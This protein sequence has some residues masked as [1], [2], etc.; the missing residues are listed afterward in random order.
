MMCFV[1]LHHRS[2]TLGNFWLKSLALLY[3]LHLCTCQEALVLE[4]RQEGQGNYTLILN[5]EAH[6]MMKIDKK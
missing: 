6:L 2:L 5:N 4:A 3:F 1:Y